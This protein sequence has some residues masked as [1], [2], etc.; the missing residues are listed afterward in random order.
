[1]K[2]LYCEKEFIPRKGTGRPRKY[3]SDECRYNADRDNKRIK[4]VGKRVSECECCG[5][6]LPKYKT[7][8]C[9]A[10]CQRGNKEQVKICIVCGQE[11]VTT[12]SAKLTCSEI[13]KKRNYYS[14]KVSR[15]ERYKGITLDKDISLYKLALRDGGICQICKRPIDW[16]DKREINGRVLCGNNYPSIDHIKPVSKGGLH[17]WDNVQLAH[18]VCNSLKSNIVV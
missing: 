18:R 2:C 6:P 5:K 4:Y 10:N 11:F 17:S 15:A 3:C 1:M 12:R 7:R 8:F 14:K 9:S 13:C 16:S